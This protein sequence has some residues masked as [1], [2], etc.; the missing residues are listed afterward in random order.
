LN[1][2]KKT[3]IS[4][5]KNEANRQVV[6]LFQEVKDFIL[7]NVS[8]K[9]DNDI[10]SS[11]YGSIIDNSIYHIR[12]TSIQ[13]KNQHKLVSLGKVRYSGS[14]LIFGLPGN[15]N[16]T[17]TLEQLAKE[18]LLKFK[19]KV[20]NQVHEILVIIMDR[21]SLY[22]R[23]DNPDYPLSRINKRSICVIGLGS[24]GSLISTY[25]AKSGIGKLTLIDGDILLEHNIIRHVCAIYDIGR[26]KTLAVR[27]YVLRR[28]PN[29][30][31]I[32]AE[33]DFSINDKYEED[34]YKELLSSVDLIV[35]AVGD[36]VMN[37]RINSFAYKNKIPVIY[38][39]AFDKITGGIMIRVDPL[40]KSICYDCIYRNNVDVE[41]T[42]VTDKVIFY[43]R[44]ADD[45]LT[46]PGLGI[47]IDLITLPAVKLILSTLL[48]DKEE[49]G[50]F[51]QDIYYWYNKNLPDRKIETF[52]LYEERRALNKRPECGICSKM[53]T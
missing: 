46:Q 44:N 24:G 21:S 5:T 49:S 48:G 19:T 20:N 37:S 33:R 42:E 13:T 16:V 22:L 1:D 47:D 27:D 8:K 53:K 34:Y 17:I 12:S 7:N 11:I 45:M 52:V 4:W 15:L 43:G 6:V 14:E 36:H 35:S 30:K 31:I 32:T 9:N 28:I 50:S 26:Y 23:I 25:L 40:K 38:A 41:H 3:T 10:E 39:G 18:K 29:V 2:L 51:T